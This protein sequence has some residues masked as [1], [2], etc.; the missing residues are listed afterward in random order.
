MYTGPPAPRS[1]ARNLA[2]EVLPRR[3][4]SYVPTCYVPSSSRSTRVTH[5]TGFTPRP[6]ATLPHVR[7]SRLL[8]G[9]PSAQ[10]DQ[11]SRNLSRLLSSTQNQQVTAQRSPCTG[12]TS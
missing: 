6:N 12:S 11:D 2:S 7:P 9:R 3:V 8:A 10:I 1:L 4:A 5:A